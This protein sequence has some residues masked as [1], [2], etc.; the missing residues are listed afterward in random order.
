[1]S[2]DDHERW[3]RIA[4]G[5]ALDQAPTPPPAA[6]LD[7]EAEAEIRAVLAAMSAMCWSVHPA[8][9]AHIA[10]WRLRIEAALARREGGR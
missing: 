3:E 9:R 6:A 8:L 2:R 4:R 1:M 5:E 7:A 10:A